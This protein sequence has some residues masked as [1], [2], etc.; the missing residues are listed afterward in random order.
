[1]RRAR[2]S[3]LAA[4]FALPSLAV[5]Q[6]FGLSGTEFRVNTYGP[7]DQYRPAVAVD[8]TGAFI[9]AWIDAG[10]DG[11]GNGIFAKRYTSAGAPI[12]TFDIEFQVNT[13]TSGSQYMPAVAAIGTGTYVVAWTSGSPSFQDGSGQGVYAQRWGAGPLG[14]EF[15]VNTDTFGHQ[16]YPVVA[17]DG[18]GNFVIAWQDTSKGD[19]L[20]RRYSSAGVPLDSPFVVNQHT[21]GNQVNPAVARSSAGDFAVFWFDGD[22]Y[23]EIHGQRYASAGA[24]QGGEFPLSTHSGLDYQ[25]PLSAAYGPS[26]FVVVWTLQ[27]VGQTE[28]IARRFAATGAPLGGE[29]QVNSVTG[30]AT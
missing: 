25:T 21:T 23:Y 14:T 9:I 10:L 19:I 16:L 3:L 15:R 12:G 28:I 20:A 5:A 22:N 7:N 8:G 17:A 13:Y 1:M 24:P 4:A 30:S 29:M 2:S 6:P 11:N 27:G 18:S 26:G